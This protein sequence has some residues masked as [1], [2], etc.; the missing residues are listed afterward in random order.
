MSK[1]EALRKLTGRPWRQ[2]LTLGMFAILQ[3]HLPILPKL[4]P[5]QDLDDCELAF[6]FHISCQP[7]P[8]CTLRVLENYF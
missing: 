6:V 7:Q 4:F 5:D 3:H 8:A 1:F 2:I